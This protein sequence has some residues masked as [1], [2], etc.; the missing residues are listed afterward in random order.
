MQTYPTALVFQAFP[1]VSIRTGL[2]E[3]VID[4]GRIYLLRDERLEKTLSVTKSLADSGKDVLCISRYHPSI[5]SGRLPL[6]NMQSIW[7]G[8]RIGDDRISPDNLGKLKHC[9]AVFAR[10]HKNGVV[11]IDGLEYDAPVWLIGSS[12]RSAVMVTSGRTLV[13]ID[14]AR[15]DVCG[16]AKAATSVSARRAG[17]R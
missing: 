16:A 4:F 15:A 8:E 2:V 3:Q 11:V 9:I 5:M 13:S 7:L 12:T 10:E 14:C 6:N 17:L 1:S